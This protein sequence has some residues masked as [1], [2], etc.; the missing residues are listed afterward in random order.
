M[1]KKRS[2]IEK[3]Y[4]WDLHPLYASHEAFESDYKRLH[5]LESSQFE[6]INRYQK[7]FE[8]H[9]GDLLK[10]YFDIS[11]QLEKLY[12]YAHLKHD[13]DLSLD[14]NKEPFKR[15][16]SLLNS[17]G[18][19]TSW[20]EP[21]ILKLDRGVL[22]SLM[23]EASLKPFEIY[24]HKMLLLKQHVLS[25]EEERL[26]ALAMQPLSAISRAFSQANNADLKFQSVLDSKGKL[27]ELTH[28]SYSLCLKSHDRT[29]RKNAFESYSK[30]FLGLE[31]TLSELLAGCVQQH[32]FFAEARKYASCLDAALFPNQIDPKVYKNLIETV[33][34]NLHPL[35]RYLNLR[36]RELKLEKLE[37]YDLFVP[38][39]QEVDLHFSF[40]E[41][42][43]LV[44]D[45]IKPLG[46][47]Y[48]SILR[49]GIEEERWT[50][51]FENTGKR[52]GAYSSGCYD[53]YPYML[54]NFNGTFS[55]VMTL[56]HEAGHSM[57]SY[58]SHKHQLYQNASYSI[59]VA[60]VAST[61]NEE[62][63]FRAL[64]DKAKNSAER[65]YI[66]NQKIDSIRSTLFRQTLFADFEL[67]IHQMVESNQPL[68]PGSLKTLYME[69]NKEYYGEAI[70]LDPL[71]AIECLR[72]P[73]FYYNFYVYQY[74]TGISAAYCLAEQVLSDAPRAKERYLG[75][76]AAGASKFP[77]D[78]LKDAG[79]DMHLP[80]AIVT[81]IKRF[82]TLVDLLEHELTRK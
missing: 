33:R 19:Q 30:G 76:L 80:E 55:D 31:N 25:E 10:N 70:H 79:V 62:L 2:E 34:E 35:H 82:E 5:Q 32:R 40:E 68:T 6:I 74:A 37:V 36:K 65:V 61:F 13:E 57:H 1:A 77:L 44:I 51:V 48:Q 4:T 14:S 45:S 58:Y 49:K 28:G 41:A 18:A 42:S 54:L 27:H 63:T 23:S 9:L 43:K 47:E 67:R 52:S 17:F 39:V 50:D 16:Q 12:T 46:D 53:S 29:L 81:L 24:L 38:I 22:K 78:V 72:I 66:L 8:S 69:L 11:R 20:I 15:A 73:H 3:K 56:S 7:N 26:L 59:F 64:L 71:V 21:M 75:F 60:E